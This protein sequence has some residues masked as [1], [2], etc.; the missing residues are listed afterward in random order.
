MA[1][2]GCQPPSRASRYPFSRGGFWLAVNGR[3]R[4][5][6]L[7]FRW[8]LGPFDWGA[9]RQRLIGRGIGVAEGRRCIG[10]MSGRRNCILT[11]DCV[12]SRCFGREAQGKV[13]IAWERAGDDLLVSLPDR[14]APLHL[15]LVHPISE[16]PSSLSEASVFSVRPHELICVTTNSGRAP[17]LVGCSGWHVYI[18][19]CPS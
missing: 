15:C 6:S 9:T 11:D 4:L 18:L 12:V 13:N 8:N 3:E 1:I 19:S 7:K 16:S 14:F 2:P 17:G 10:I 5:L